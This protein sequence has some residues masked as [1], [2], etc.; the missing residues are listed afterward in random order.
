MRTA[1][2]TGLSLDRLKVASCLVYVVLLD[3]G[4]LDG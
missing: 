2:A 1:G 3:L 4:S